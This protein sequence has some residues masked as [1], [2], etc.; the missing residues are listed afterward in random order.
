[1]LQENDDLAGAAPI[2]PAADQ[3][4]LSR[5]RAYV[6]PIL[7]RLGSIMELT[8]GNTGTAYDAV[9]DHHY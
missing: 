8:K 3:D 6:K 2:D 5:R 7:S 9:Q 4:A 1:M